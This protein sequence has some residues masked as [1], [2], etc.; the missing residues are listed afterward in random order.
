MKRTIALVLEID[1]DFIKKSEA[2]WRLENRICNSRKLDEMI[3]EV[4][5]DSCVGHYA[6][7]KY[8]D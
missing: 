8:G 4:F 6:D 2:I 7:G 5:G 1:D 3:A